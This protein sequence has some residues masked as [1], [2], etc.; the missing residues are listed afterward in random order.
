MGLRFE[1]SKQENKKRAFYSQSPPNFISPIVP[2]WYLP[3][4]HAEQ[5][6]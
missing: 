6:I 1:P 3:M 4:H 2:L 5:D